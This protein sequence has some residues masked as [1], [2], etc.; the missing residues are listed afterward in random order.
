MEK[1]EKIKG[2]QEIIKKLQENSTSLHIARI[3][4][5]SK[6]IFREFADKE[7]CGDYGMALKWLVDGIPNK[8]FD[9]IAAQLEIHDARLTKLENIPAPTEEPK[10]IKM[11]S[12]KEIEV[13]KK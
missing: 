7:F 12:G 9:V 1:K 2:A 11:L 3:P 13:K 8:D 10:K 6:R 5:Q 4:I